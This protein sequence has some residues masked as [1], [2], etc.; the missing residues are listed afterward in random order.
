[1]LGWQRGAAQRARAQAEGIGGLDHP[2]PEH[3]STRLALAAWAFMGRGWAPERLALFLRLHPSAVA[4][5]ALLIEL[6]EI[7]RDGA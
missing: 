5:G 6:L 4:H 3:P 7:M 2:P 1:M